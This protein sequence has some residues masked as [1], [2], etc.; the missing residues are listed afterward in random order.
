MKKILLVEDDQDIA[1]ALSLRLKVSSYEVVTA[2]DA[3]AG[4]TAAARENPDLVILDI[5][6]PG[7]SGIEVARRIQAMTTTIA[8][9]II[10]V[11]ASMKSEIRQQAYELGAIG[12]F[13]KPF[14]AQDILECI[15]DALNPA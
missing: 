8:P 12:F 3:V 15:E 7:G 1:R 9:P 13:E 4:T 14:S 10:F 6:I 2:F 5:S 11:T